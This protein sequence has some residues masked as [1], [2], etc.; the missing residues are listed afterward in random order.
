M[1]SE[2]LVLK[3]LLGNKGAGFT[4]K[5]ISEG[6]KINYRI[7]Y[8]KAISLEK[9]GLIK[10]EKQG[11]SKIC[12]LAYKFD[13]KIFEAEY[14]RRQELFKNKDF[15][16]IHN[17]LSKLEFPFVALLFG[18]YAKGTQTKHSD[19]D[20]L[21]IGGEEKEI[22]SNLTLLFSDKIHLTWMTH[23][24]FLLMAKSREFTVVS[25]AMKNNVILIGIEEYYRLLENAG[26][27]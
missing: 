3:F 15:L 23:K 14:L 2:I 5:K 13:W 19:M 11:N 24:D 26:P 6:A 16:I 8:E 27:V 21:A 20:I 17:H 4:I 10:I 9:D 22:E 12:N 25:E 7:A 18:S 1:D